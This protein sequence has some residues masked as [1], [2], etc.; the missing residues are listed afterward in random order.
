MSSS[1]SYSN[2]TNELFNQWKCKYLIHCGQAEHVSPCYQLDR[3]PH[4]PPAPFDGH[5]LT[6]AHN[7][8]IRQHKS[9]MTN[10]RLNYK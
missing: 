7:L 4:H 2:I 6:P 1:V 8:F 5:K 10:K 9:D 3:S